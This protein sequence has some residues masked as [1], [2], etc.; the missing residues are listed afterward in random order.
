MSGEINKGKT[1]KREEE[2]GAHPWSGVMVKGLGYSL[3][4]CSGSQEE[5]VGSQ[6]LS[7]RAKGDLT[8]ANGKRRIKQI[9]RGAPEG[10]EPSPP[11][12]RGGPQELTGNTWWGGKNPESP[13]GGLKD[14]HIASRGGEEGIWGGPG[15][16]GPPKGQSV[17][18]GTQRRR[19]TQKEEGDSRIH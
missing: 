2:A 17:G 10:G 18:T 14:G 11:H 19:G 6:A 7:G 12:S 5:F 16:R 4:A 13:I 9:T 15:Q 8:A 3:K 1:I